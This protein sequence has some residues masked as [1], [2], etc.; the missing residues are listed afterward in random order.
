[1]GV[2]YPSQ[3]S[4]KS[5]RISYKTGRISYKACKGTSHHK[6]TLK[7][8]EASLREAE[9]CISQHIF[10]LS[11]LCILSRS[12]SPLIVLPVQMQFPSEWLFL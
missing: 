12:A 1:M 7:L 10:I 11:W 9:A 4:L 2:G 8:R 3:R 6:R 5:S